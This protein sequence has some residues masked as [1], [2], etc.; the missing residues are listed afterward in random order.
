MF[1]FDTLYRDL[2]DTRFEPWLERLPT[3]LEAVFQE[4]THGF[5]EEWIRLLDAM[6]KVVPTDNDL[7]ADRVRIGRP[8][9]LD[10]ESRDLLEQQLR[11]IIPWRKGP[12]EIFGI[13]VNTEWRSDY[14]WQ[15]IRSHIAPLA[16]RSV[17]DVGC[18]NGYHMWRMLGEG[19]ELVLGADPSQF[20]VA[21]F[22]AIKQYAGEGLPVHLLPMKCEQLPAFTRE[23]RGIGFD[24]VFSM[25]VLYHRASPVT[26][27]QELRS[28]LRPGGELILETLVIE[29][30]EQSV[31]VP[32][33]RYAKMRN[34][35]FISSTGFLIRLLERV[36]FINCRVVDECVTSLDEQRATD[37]MT[38]ESL[39]S[40]L[41]QD[42]HSKTIE[43]YPAPR[44]A[45]LICQA[46]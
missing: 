6:P 26:H 38:F 31:L 4:K 17:L 32:E 2:T 20:F 10:D 35:W 18:G 19:A 23:Y 37:W 9:D 45:T 3:Q 30:D 15:R 43:G 29:G 21:Q 22:R 24:T 1:N 39:E 42:D 46:P 11:T 44:R 36:G 16:G 25:G 5:L 13:H 27:L 14:K 8:E 40:F 28:F 33:D 34:V 12:Y 7:N 41:D